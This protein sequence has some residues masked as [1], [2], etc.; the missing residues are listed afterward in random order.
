M[1]YILIILI[2]FVFVI[3]T[4]IK[5][6]KKKQMIMKYPEVKCKVKTRVQIDGI[7]IPPG[8]EFNA[9]LV[10]YISVQ[11][12]NIPEL[13][14][15]MVIDKIGNRNYDN[16]IIPI[17]RKSIEVSLKEDETIIDNFVNS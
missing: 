11:N 12:N 2:I 5:T 6:I 15:L 1:N 17:P 4:I 13:F 10:Q 3:I 8:A 16:I 7:S 14:V 9:K